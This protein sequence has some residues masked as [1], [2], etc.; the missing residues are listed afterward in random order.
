MNEREAATLVL[1]LANAFPGAKFTE[2]TAKIYEEKLAPFVAA[3][4]QNAI[5][6]LISTARYL[7]PV[8]D[9]KAEIFRVRRERALSNDNARHLAVRTVVDASPNPRLW[10]GPLSRMLEQAAHH[11]EMAAKWYAERG[12]KV[13]EDPGAAFIETAK[14]GARGEDVR[15]R[16]SQALPYSEELERRYP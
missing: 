11:R 12:K 14:A 8:A 1:R 7:P 3:E 9:I 4:A 2:E 16:V 6:E 5:E 13:P 15:E 10:E